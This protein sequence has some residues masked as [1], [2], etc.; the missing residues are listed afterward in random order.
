MGARG[1]DIPEREASQPL[2]PRAHRSWTPTARALA[3]AGD[4]WTLLIVLQMAPGRMRLQRLRTC[5][6]GVSTGVLE[7]YVQQMVALG[8]LTRSRHREMPPRVELELTD[9]GRELLPIAAELSR[10]GMRHM[11]TPAREG[12]CVEVD[13]LLC[14]LP[15][16]L[17]GHHDLPDGSFE[18]TSVHADGESVR[19]RFR[20][21]AGCLEMDERTSGRPTARAEG[22]RSAWIAALGPEG[23]LAGLSIS[24]DRRMATRVLEALHPHG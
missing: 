13:A 2:T 8:L 23:E 18:A 4:D 7:R 6:P 3:A 5:L 24:G 11:W 21:R 15:V 22:E 12:E 16:L 20:V 9:A 19:H 1:A 14:L 10:W 17:E